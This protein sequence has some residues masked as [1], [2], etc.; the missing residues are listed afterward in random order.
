[1]NDRGTGRTTKQLMALPLR[2][3]YIV[4]H[5]QELE[6]TKRLAQH[7]GRQDVRLFTRDDIDHRMN[8]LEF[9]VLE[10]DHACDLSDRQRAQYRARCDYQARIPI[11]P[12]VPPDD[13]QAYWGCMINDVGGGS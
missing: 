4:Q 11:E 1:M 2:A 9:S 10:L 3:G 13:S 8:G 5:W 7:L 12:Y 6:H